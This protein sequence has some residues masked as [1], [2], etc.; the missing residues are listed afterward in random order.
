MTGFRSHDPIPVLKPCSVFLSVL[1][2]WKTI[3][4]VT[5]LNFWLR[6]KGL[7]LSLFFSDRF[8]REKK[9]ELT[10]FFKLLELAAAKWRSEGRAGAI[11]KDG[12][13][14][15]SQFIIC[16]IA[17]RCRA[18]DSTKSTTQRSSEA[19]ESKLALFRK[20][21]RLLSVNDLFFQPLRK[22]SSAIC[23]TGR[24]KNV[25]TSRSAATWFPPKRKRMESRRRSRKIKWKTAE[26]MA[27]TLNC[28]ITY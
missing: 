2:L 5:C 15:S 8:S 10:N 11:W 17:E 13:S 26:E 14:A 25:K 16:R 9:P 24:S 1:L 22:I 27:K 6:T 4:P 18:T 21:S 12:L 7:F 20:E 28:L 23:F 19:A 3:C